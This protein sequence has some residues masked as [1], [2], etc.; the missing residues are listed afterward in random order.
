MTIRLK[1]KEKE[2]ET[3]KESIK[4]AHKNFVSMARHKELEM[5][6]GKYTPKV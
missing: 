1:E 6:L 3:Y 4:T 5:L 2:D